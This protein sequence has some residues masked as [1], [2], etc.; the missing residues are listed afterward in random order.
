MSSIVPTCD[1]LRT[2]TISYEF[3]M[4]E[5]VYHSIPGLL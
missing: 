4:V 3:A 1:F 2:F 5:W